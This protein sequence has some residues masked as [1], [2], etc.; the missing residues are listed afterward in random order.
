MLIHI[1]EF[2]ELDR[3]NGT[4]KRRLEEVRLIP[5]VSFFVA[6]HRSSVCTENVHLHLEF[7]RGIRVILLGLCSLSLSPCFDLISSS[8]SDSVVAFEL[9]LIR[10]F[11]PLLDDAD[12]P[13][14]NDLQLCNLMASSS[15][16]SSQ[17][18]LF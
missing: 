12:L 9:L 8:A 13:A 16:L 14:L 18:T 17:Q 2:C 5:E 1:G 10:L 4:S 3:A 7:P 6:E 15:L 11:I